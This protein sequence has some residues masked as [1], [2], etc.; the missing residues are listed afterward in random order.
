MLEA[1]GLLGDKFML[2]SSVGMADCI[3]REMDELGVLP[4]DTGTFNGLPSCSLMKP[5]LILYRYTEDKKYLDFCLKIADRWERVE[6]MPAIIANS[7]SDKR[8][9]EWY[10]DS[11]KWAKAYEMMSCFEGLLE[12]YRVTGNDDCKTAVVNFVDAVAKTDITVA[13]ASTAQESSKA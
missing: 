10:P 13:P 2:D 1:Y 9:R 5:M 3:I 6:I 7:L 12:Y 4:N 11:N 8:I